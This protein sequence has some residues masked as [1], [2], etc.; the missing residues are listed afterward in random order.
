MVTSDMNNWIRRLAMLPPKDVL[1]SFCASPH[2]KA[3]PF[4]EG[5]NR[6]FICEECVATCATLIGQEKLRRTS[7]SAVTSNRALYLSA[8]RIPVR[9][10][11]EA[12]EF[13]QSKLGFLLVSQSAADNYLVFLAGSVHIVTEQ[14]DADWNESGLTATGRFTGL[15]FAVASA[16]GTHKEL[17]SVGV[18]FTSE[19]EM[20]SWGGVLA[21]FKDPTG[22]L[23]QIVEHPL[24]T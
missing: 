1:C 9:D 18:C 13:Y 19:P 5:P 8:A 3:G 7:D 17:T 10:L 24:E 16:K 20:Q 6:S 2:S 4:A 11:D 21:T 23:L 15:S 22:N 12:K 14:V